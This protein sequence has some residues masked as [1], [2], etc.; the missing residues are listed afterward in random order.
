MSE[1]SVAVDEFDTKE[2]A[3]EHRLNDSFYFDYFTCHKRKSLPEG[4]GERN[5]I[6]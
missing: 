6:P 1:D 2:G 4:Q 5:L 3:F